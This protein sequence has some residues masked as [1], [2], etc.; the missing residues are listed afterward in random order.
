MVCGNLGHDLLPFVS[1]TSQTYTASVDEF[2]DIPHGPGMVFDACCHRGG[3]PGSG[4]LWLGFVK[5]NIAMPVM[6]GASPSGQGLRIVR[7]PAM[8][9]AAR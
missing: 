3:L 7:E 4:L 1:V 8:A 6:G 5:Y 9:R 2:D